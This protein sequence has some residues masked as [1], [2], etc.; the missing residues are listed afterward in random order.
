VHRHLV[1]DVSV[2]E[3]APYELRE[4]DLE[5]AARL[6]GACREKCRPC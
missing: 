6:V 3:R 1:A 2:L 4:G 5:V